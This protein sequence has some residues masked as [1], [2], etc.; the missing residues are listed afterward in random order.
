MMMGSS[1]DHLELWEPGMLAGEAER[2]LQQVSPIA[3]L[4]KEVKACCLENRY[5]PPAPVYTPA[6]QPPGTPDPDTTLHYKKFD[7]PLGRRFNE[8]SNQSDDTI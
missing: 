2:I 7:T 5:S 3:R 6:Y 4:F 1:T 8:Q